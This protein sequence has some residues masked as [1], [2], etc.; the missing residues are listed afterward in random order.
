VHEWVYIG[1]QRLRMLYLQT[2]NVENGSLIDKLF[3]ESLFSL[4]CRTL[5]RVCAL[6][7]GLGSS[8]YR[9]VSINPGTL[10]L[11]GSGIVI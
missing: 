10:M 3:Y 8:M 9:S 11:D 6:H 7:R 2:R 4:V 5:S 1:K